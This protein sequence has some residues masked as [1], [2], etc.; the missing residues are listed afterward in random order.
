M[1]RRSGSYGR[2]T[3]ELQQYIVL[4]LFSFSLRTVYKIDWFGT[5]GEGAGSPRDCQRLH[6]QVTK[7]PST[8][9]RIWRANA[10]RAQ[11]VSILEDQAK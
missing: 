5:S 1:L 3:L 7:E 2:G 4:L 9:S 10:S 11:F 6:V 8:E